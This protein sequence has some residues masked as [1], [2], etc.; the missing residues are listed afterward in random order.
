MSFKKMVKSQYPSRLWALVGYPGSGKSTF[1]TQMRGPIL[2]IDADHRFGEVLDLVAEHVVS[3]VAGHGD[4]FALSDAP[5]DHVDADRITALLAANMPGSGVRTIVVDSL[6]AIITPLVVQAIIDKEAGREKNLAAAFRTKALAMRQLQD[7]VTRWGCDTLWV[8]HLNDARDAQGK[9][10]VRATVSQTELARLTRSINAQIELVQDG[11][12]CGAR[13]VWARRGRSGMTLW[14]ETRTWAGM[15]E[16]IEAAVYDG[17]TTVDQEK[18][19]RTIPAGFPDEA[20]AI[21]WGFEQG[22]FQAL[23]HARNAYNKLKKAHKDLVAQGH[24]PGHVVS[25]VAGQLAGLWIADVQARLLAN[26]GS[27]NS[28]E[29]AP[30]SPTAWPDTRPGGVVPEQATPELPSGQGNGDGDPGE[31]DVV[32]PRYS[33]GSP[34]GDNPAEMATFEAYLQDR[35]IPP[36][37]LEALRA[38]ELARRKAQPHA[39]SGRSAHVVTVGDRGAGAKGK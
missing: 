3:A 4:V 5:A 29:G 38:W 1:A 37:S 11:P 9:A 28:P 10:L 34:L 23:Q 36:A 6:T 20:T 26:A 14:D 17:L 22:A 24:Q 39:P 25:A 33:D 32:F 2:V 35:T 12:R 8:Y 27:D 21:A 30:R 13:V 31:L 15:P 18:I 7:A 19:E 16:K